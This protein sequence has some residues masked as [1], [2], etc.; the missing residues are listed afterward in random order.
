MHKRPADT[1]AAHTLKLNVF[2]G[3]AYCRGTSSCQEWFF[4]NSRYVRQDNPC[5]RP[6]RLLLTALTH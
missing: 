5:V 2:L 1:P 6:A 4:D 3:A